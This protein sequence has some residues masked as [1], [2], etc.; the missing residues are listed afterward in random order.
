MFFNFEI[1][2][3][4]NKPLSKNPDSAKEYTMHIQDMNKLIIQGGGGFAG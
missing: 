2:F 4:W 3:F 1:R